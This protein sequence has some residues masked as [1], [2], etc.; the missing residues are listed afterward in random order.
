MPG[1]VGYTLERSLRCPGTPCAWHRMALTCVHRHVYRR[2][3]PLLN[4]GWHILPPWK[5]PP[6]QGGAAAEGNQAS[7]L[8]PSVGGT[9]GAG[10]VPWHL[11]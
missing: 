4:R 5:T 1:E 8:M 10:W 11:G 3:G 6:V 2:G 7:F 9:W